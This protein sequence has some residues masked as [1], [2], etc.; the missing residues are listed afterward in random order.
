VI[1]ER[2]DTNGWLRAALGF[3][4]PGALLA[5]AIG[6]VLA[7]GDR[8]PDPLASHWGVARRPDG[9]M[10]RAALLVL[11]GL[12][13]GV[14][15]VASALAVRR[16]PTHRGKLAPSLAVLGFIGAAGAGVSLL[17][18]SANL[19]ATA[20]HEAKEIG[21]AGVGALVLGAAGWAAVVGLLGR[22]LEAL[23]TD[24][25]RSRR[26]SAG[27]ASGERALWIGH[28]RARWPWGV[29]AGCLALAVFQLV[30]V[31]A[32]SA[33]LCIGVAIAML[34]VTSIR[35][36][37]DRRGVRVEFGALG[38]PVARV[39]LDDIEAAHSVDLRPMQWGGWGYRGGLR[40]FG[41]AAVV[42]RAGDALLLDVRGGRQFAVT[43][44]DAETAAGVVNDLLVA[45]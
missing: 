15:A 25:G 4:L 5:L 9:A 38:W 29:L 19:D 35:V 42:L 34:P 1:D 36:G 31:G 17:I 6:P 26:P 33:L 14:P 18:V 37:V 7:A 30:V 8:L 45:R 41:K 32:F 13:T 2:T 12:L 20:W 10:S 40:L 21:L 27:L 11:C 43:V 3:V 24:P 16:A 22:R 39:P 28:A 44:D 23:G